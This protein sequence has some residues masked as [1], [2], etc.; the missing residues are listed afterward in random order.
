MSRLIALILLAALS[1]AA[2]GATGVRVLLGLTDKASTKWDGGVSARGARIV[3]L[4]PWRFEGQDAITGNQWRSRLIP[5][6]CSAPQRTPRPVV[7][8]GVIVWLDG[9]SDATEL[10]VKTPQGAFTVKLGDIPFGKVSFALSRAAMTDR[11][12][13]ASRITNSPD[14]QDYPAAAVDKD[15]AIWMAYVEFRHNKDHHKLRAPLTQAP[16]NFAALKAPTGGDQILLRKYCG[17]DMG[18]HCRHHAARRRPVATGGRRRRKGRPWVFWWRNERGN[19]DLWARADRKRTTRRNGTHLHRP[20]S[21]I[22]PVAATDSS[23]RVWVAWQG[24]RN[25]KASI[26]AAAQKGNSFS[27]AATGPSSGGN[28]WNP[29]IAADSSGRVTVAWDS[30]RNGNYDVFVRTAASR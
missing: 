25:G 5:S 18:R 8:N 12:P 28:E 30:Y 20:G 9:E 10:S 16:A 4:E 15:G 1:T 6:G 26:F 23:G 21:D 27:K 22:D 19:F 17:R 7:A 2:H 14:E 24:W 13:A 29:A 3:S 11:I